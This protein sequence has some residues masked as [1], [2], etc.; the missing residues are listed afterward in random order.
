MIEAKDI[1]KYEK[2]AANAIHGYAADENITCYTYGRDMT[3]LLNERLELL[4]QVATLEKHLK[5]REPY[6]TGSAQ[7]PLRGM[8]ERVEEQPKSKSKEK[9]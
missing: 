7:P 8:P 5:D 4:K 1:A 3:A 6:L 9:A 2:R